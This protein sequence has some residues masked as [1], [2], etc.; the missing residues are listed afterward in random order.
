[1]DLPFL[2]AAEILGRRWEREEGRDE[3]ETEEEEE[4][5]EEGEEDEEEGQP[6]QR[7]GKDREWKEIASFAS[8]DLYKESELFTELNSQM[9]RRKE[10]KE[11]NTKFEWFICREARRKGRM[12]CPRVLKVGFP[13]WSHEVVVYGTDDDHQHGEDEGHQTKTYYH[14]TDAQEAVIRRCIKNKV[15]KNNLILRELRELNLTNA[16]GLLPNTSQ[17]IDFWETNLYT[18]NVKEK[19]ISFFL[20]RLGSRSATCA[21]SPSKIPIYWTL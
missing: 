17:V 10:S 3:S 18:G 1:M 7:R 12:K 8:N 9:T 2:D 21:M 14:W 5:E 16:T 13:Q 20:V 11:G 4:E 19:Q 6:K 15:F